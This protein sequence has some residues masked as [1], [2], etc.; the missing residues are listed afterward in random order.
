[1]DKQ[2]IMFQFTTAAQKAHRE[3]CWTFVHEL[4]SETLARKFTMNDSP[5]VST[6][7]N[8][9]KKTIVTLTSAHSNLK[10]GKRIVSTINKTLM[11]K[12]GLNTHMTSYTNNDGTNK[13]VISIDFEQS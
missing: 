6:I 12:Y 5:F 11:N 8:I 13:N 2:K 10:N 9:P 3:A 1:M 4:G 7:N